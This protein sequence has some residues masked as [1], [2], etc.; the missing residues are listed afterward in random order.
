MGFSRGPQNAPKAFHKVYTSL[1]LGELKERY[2][3]LN[4]DRKC[5]VPGWIRVEGLRFHIIY[6]SLYHDREC[7]SSMDPYSGNLPYI[8]SV[9][10]MQQKP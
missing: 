6:G 1:V 4:L 9:T 8:H 5:F 7:T 10:G 3:L 2:V